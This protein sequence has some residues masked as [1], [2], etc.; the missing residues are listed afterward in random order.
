MYRHRRG[1]HR[2]L[3]MKPEG[4]G[5]LK[6]LSMYGIILKFIIKQWDGGMDWILLP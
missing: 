4:K 2:V 3:L 1:A 5:P 6:K